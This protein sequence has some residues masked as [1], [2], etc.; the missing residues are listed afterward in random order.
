MEPLAQFHEEVRLGSSCSER[1]QFAAALAHY[2]RASNIA[3]ERN[4]FALFAKAQLNTANVY[5]RQQNFA[6]VKEVL[7]PLLDKP[8]E[9]AD[10]GLVLSSLANAFAHDG[11]F[12]RADEYHRQSI[13]LLAQVH[14]PQ[15]RKIMGG[16]AAWL[17][18]RGLYR[19]ALNCLEKACDVERPDYDILFNI[20]L[21]HFRLGQLHQCGDALEQAY[22]CAQQHYG[23]H[24]NHSARVVL[25]ALQLKSQH[26]IWRTRADELMRVHLERFRVTNAEAQLHAIGPHLELLDAYAEV[27]LAANAPTHAAEFLLDSTTELE[28]RIKQDQDKLPILFRLLKR[29]RELASTYGDAAIHN[30][31]ALKLA[32]LF[33]KR[34]CLVRALE[35]V[36]HVPFPFAAVSRMRDELVRSIHRE[37][38]KLGEAS[39]RNLQVV[40]AKEEKVLI[41]RCFSCTLPADSCVK[42]CLRT[43]AILTAVAYVLGRKSRL[44]S[45]LAGA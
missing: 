11:D 2:H 31:V 4:D 43:L 26:K 45:I 39:F 27:L 41:S 1:Q 10:L 38:Q 19:E 3:L 18:Q 33:E 30:S 25:L 17:S 24:H 7:T 32:E 8:I 20:P 40:L 44:Q 23:Q 15:L 34:R 21:Q 37:S 9:A 42:P 13:S 5:G 12:E 6:A 22:L 36:S 29:T 28:T 16:R 14:S 35:E